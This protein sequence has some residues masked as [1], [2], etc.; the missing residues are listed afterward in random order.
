MCWCVALARTTANGEDD[1]RTM[2]GFRH[3]FMPCCVGLGSFPAVL[4]GPVARGGGALEMNRNNEANHNAI[5]RRRP[6]VFGT[7]G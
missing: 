3:L 7:L 1:V 2:D 6:W 4:S 5:S